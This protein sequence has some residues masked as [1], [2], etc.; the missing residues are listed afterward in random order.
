MFH[1]ITTPIYYVNDRPH[2]GHVY[3]SL[4]GDILARFYRLCGDHVKF[5]TG[6]DEHGGKVAAAAE[7]KGVTPQ[8]YV[9]CMAGAFRQL[10][11]VG[12]IQIDDFVRTT[13]SRHHRA[14][15]ALWARLEARDQIY[16]G[17]YSGWYAVRDE[18]YYDAS[19][20]I[21][22]PDGKRAPTGAPV[23]WVQEDCYFFRLS[24]WAQPL[25]DY[26][27]ANPQAIGPESRRNEVLS[28]L[29]TGLR[30]LAVSR[31]KL[32]WGIPIVNTASGTSAVATNPLGDV[33]VDTGAGDLK[34]S[35]VAERAGAHVG[36]QNITTQHVMYVWVDALTNYLTVL[37]YPDTENPDFA[38]Y[39][40]QATHL[41]GKDI[42]RFHAV[43]WPALLMA[44]GLVP[45]KRVFAHGW[46]MSEGQKMSK[47]LGNVIDPFAL[48]RDYGVDRVRYFLFRHVRFGQDGDFSKA[49]FDQRC[50]QELADGLG[51]LAHRVLSFIANRLDGFIPAYHAQPND[52]QSNDG[53]LGLM[54]WASDQY[55]LWREF[56]D[57]Q[58]I[59]AYLESLYTGIQKGNG[60][61]A[62]LAPWN[63]LK[64]AN[65]G[66]AGARV[67]MNNGLHGL[68]C[69]LRDLAIALWPVMPETAESLWAQV[70]MSGTIAQ[71]AVPGKGLLDKG[72]LD[73][74][75]L[76]L[77]GPGAW[78]DESVGGTEAGPQDGA[79][80]FWSLDCTKPLPAPR[81]LFAKDLVSIQ[82]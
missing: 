78:V 20:L 17:Q 9:D 74:G 15:S 36:S 32:T 62:Q 41:M 38:N 12:N 6:T 11:D 76:D 44:A 72:L 71:R 57:H 64:L 43:Y 1:Y 60:Y 35:C 16:L 28:F 81:P 75:L 23:E 56:L 10:I 13:E 58:N 82:V 79:L 80:V 54:Q 19:E 50:S 25:I 3:T 24:Q 66:D 42:V 39:W 69:F 59:Y 5:V 65:A 31:S 53:A 4:A 55:P 68:V 33:C 70:G 73:K 63:L 37:G 46:W 52:G 22:T 26:Y 48:I 14:A 18:A 67:A 49:L 2:L 21:D 61:M 47:T 29:K 45:P 30:D 51:N 34:E 8:D 7:K 40:P 27:E 77:Q